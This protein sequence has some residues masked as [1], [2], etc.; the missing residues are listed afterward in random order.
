VHDFLTAARLLGDR[1]LCCVL[2]F[3]YFNRAVFSSLDA[4]LVRLQPFLDAWPRDVPLAVEVRNKNWLTA[5]LTDCLR[6]YQTV[7][8]LPDQPWMP[9]PLS[10]V[11]KLDVVTVPFA[12]IRLLGDRAEVDALTR[13]LDHIVIDRSDQL[14]ADAEAIQRLRQRVP[15]LALVNNHFAGY[16]PETLRELARLIALTASPD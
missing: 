14:R 2:Q 9:P 3:G 7:C 16:A 15:V 12:Y 4:F 6:T 13:T 1:L 10:V 5:E 8:V 11:Q